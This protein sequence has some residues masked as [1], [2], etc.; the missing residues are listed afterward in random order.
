MTST[1]LNA[2]LSF[3]GCT[4]VD[5]GKLLLFSSELAAVVDAAPAVPEAAPVAVVDAAAAAFV[6][7]ACDDV[8]AAPFPTWPFEVEVSEVGS[9]EVVVVES[10]EGPRAVWSSEA[11]LKAARETKENGVCERGGRRESAKS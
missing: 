9:P 4:R 10:E 3:N 6:V 11:G 7:G 5:D 8:V 1:V 2:Q